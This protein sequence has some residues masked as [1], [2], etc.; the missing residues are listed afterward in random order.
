MLLMSS[1]TVILFLGGWLPLFNTTILNW[2]PF[3]IWFSVK[4]CFLVIWFRA[5]LPRYRYD[6]LMTLG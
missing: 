3:S 1:L 5:I 4:T 6:Q 2:I